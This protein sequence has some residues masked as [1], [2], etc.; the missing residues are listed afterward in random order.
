MD[1]NVNTDLL[2]YSVKSRQ[3]NLEKGLFDK[4]SDKLNKMIL[5][6]NYKYDI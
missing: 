6:H 1:K 5:E 2:E 4:I 3:K